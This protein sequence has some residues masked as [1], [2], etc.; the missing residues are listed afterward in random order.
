MVLKSQDTLRILSL[1]LLS[2][3][4]VCSATKFDPY[5]LN[6]GLVSAVAGRDYVVIASDTRMVGAG[7]YDIVERQHVTSRLW[8]ATEVE[9]DLARSENDDRSLFRQDGSVVLR[10]TQGSEVGTVQQLRRSIPFRK[11]TSFVNKGPPV[12]IGSSGCNADCEGLKRSIRSDLRVAGR[13]HEAYM[14]VNQVATLL[15]QTLYSRRTFPFYTFC[16]VAGLETRTK[17]GRVFAYDA[18]GSYESVSVACSGSGKELLQPILDRRFRAVSTMNDFPRRT[19]RL[20]NTPEPIVD[21]SKDDAIDILVDSYRAA[22]EGET[23]VGDQLVLCVLRFD[24]TKCDDKRECYVCEV[25]TSPLKE[26]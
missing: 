25:W 24:D 20:G 16:I 5:Q 23:S 26:H 18:I 12:F 4:D 13:A 1:L 8:T 7:G 22:S 10:E 9:E 14:H 17:N 15:S 21:C 2:S 6:G 11:R 19:G 3:T